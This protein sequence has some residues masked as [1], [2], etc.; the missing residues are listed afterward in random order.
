MKNEISG[1]PQLVRG[2]CRGTAD[3]HQSWDGFLKAQHFRILPACIL[4]LLALAPVASAQATL[5]TILVITPATASPGDRLTFFIETDFDGTPVNIQFYS[6]RVWFLDG[7]LI[8]F[9]FLENITRFTPGRIF[10][11]Y[12]IPD[13][14]TGIYWITARGTYQGVNATGSAGVTIVRPSTEVQVLK[15]QVGNL[16]TSVKTLS[17]EVGDLSATLRSLNTQVTMLNN[18]LIYTIAAC[19]ALGVLAIVVSLLRRRY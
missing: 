16:S 3:R 11:N 17:S 2:K 8:K 7:S 1:I 18:A 10:G 19:M 9:Q 15:S 6:L 13:N 12:T 4:F 14:A 5:L